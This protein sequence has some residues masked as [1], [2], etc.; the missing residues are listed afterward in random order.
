MVCVGEVLLSK[1]NADSYLKR[2]AQTRNELHVSRGETVQ[3]ADGPVRLCSVR[4]VGTYAWK[5]FLKAY[6]KMNHFWVL[7]F[8]Y[9]KWQTVGKSCGSTII[10][11][12]KALNPVG[13][14][15]NIF[16]VVARSIFI[17]RVT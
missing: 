10:S 6:G 14:F 3:D 1:P 17:V 5:E 2:I 8:P 11:S 7:T 13:L 9:G 12:P 4:S 15:L 16:E